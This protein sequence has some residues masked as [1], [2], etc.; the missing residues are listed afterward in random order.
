MALTQLAP[1][2]GADNAA[3]T[4]ANTGFS[5]IIKT[6]TAATVTFQNTW[7]PRG[8]NSLEFLGTTTAGYALAEMTPGTSSD[9]IAVDVPFK[10]L[11][12]PTAETGIVSFHQ[13]TDARQFSFSLYANGSVRVRDGG[14][15]GR[16][17]ETITQTAAG[18]VALNTAYILR[19]F[20][21]RDA[22]AGSY[23]VQIV[24]EGDGSVVIDSGLMTAQN[25]GSATITHMK[26]GSKMSSSSVQPTKIAYGVPRYDWAASGLVPLWA[27]A[28]AHMPFWYSDGSSWRP[29]HD[30]VYSD[31]SAW[32]SIFGVG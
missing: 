32:R 28:V 29:A 13:T 10:V 12:M 8:V 11:E 23:R 16:W 15:V 30:V 27:A 31:G 18:V 3:A 7:L 5:A 4:M 14:N 25:T 22:A 24:N 9:A 6:D 19:L 21:T 1:W 26:V 2:S 17:N 20:F